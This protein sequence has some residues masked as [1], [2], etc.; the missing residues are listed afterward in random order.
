MTDGRL[1]LTHRYLQWYCSGGGWRGGLKE[2]WALIFPSCVNMG[3]SCSILERQLSEVYTFIDVS[4]LSQISILDCYTQEMKR[5]A[6]VLPQPSWEPKEAGQVESMA[7]DGVCQHCCWA[8]SDK[9]IIS[10]A[11]NSGHGGGGVGKEKWRNLF[12]VSAA[13]RGGGL[14]P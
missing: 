13:K 14:K 7:P 2:S 5:W 9:L 3:K 10:K 8:N 4:H 12:R 1:S 11:S 6:L